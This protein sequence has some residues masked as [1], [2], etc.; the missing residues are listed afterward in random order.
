MLLRSP[1]NAHQRANRPFWLPD[2][3]HGLKAL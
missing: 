3:L 2:S 1:L